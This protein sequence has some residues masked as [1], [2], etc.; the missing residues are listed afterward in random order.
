MYDRMDVEG[1]GFGVRT[2]GRDNEIVSGSWFGLVW[3]GRT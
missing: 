2:G 3:L 1:F